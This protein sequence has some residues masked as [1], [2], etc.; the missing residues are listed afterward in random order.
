MFPDPAEEA[1]WFNLTNWGDDLVMSQV[2]TFHVKLLVNRI[3]ATEIETIRCG[4]C[5]FAIQSVNQ[6]VNAWDNSFLGCYRHETTW[7]VY[8]YR[9][10]CTVLL[11][12]NDGHWAC[13][14]DWHDVTLNLDR[15][16]DLSCFFAYTVELSLRGNQKVLVSFEGALHL[17]NL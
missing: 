7:W 1:A 9:S 13:L 3:V 12:N 8:L 2:F 14:T 4:N 5:N 10:E 11:S 17:F 6:F 16:H 15:A